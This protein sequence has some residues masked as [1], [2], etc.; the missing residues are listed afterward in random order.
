MS[1]DASEVF[2][3]ANHLEQAITTAEPELRKVTERGAFN[4]KRN[5][6]RRLSGI[7]R[8]HYLKHYYRALSY[9]MDDDG[10][11]A[12]IGPDASKPQGKMGR[13]VEFG[14]VHTQPFPH[15]FPS[16]DEEEPKYLDQVSRAII[17][18]L[19]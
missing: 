15:L 8:R 7:S 12:D 9:D 5:S 19:K 3:Y 1:A 14:S 17:Q 4:I 16:L 18:A 6:Q 10:L 11:G 13:G 2:A